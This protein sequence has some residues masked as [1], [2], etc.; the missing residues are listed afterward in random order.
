MACFLQ[1]CPL[2]APGA[3]DFLIPE[4]SLHQFLGSTACVSAPSLWLIAFGMKLA[5]SKRVQLEKILE[6]PMATLTIKDLQTHRDLDT[7]A[8]S[9]IRGANGSG[10]WV[11]GWIRPFIEEVTPRF[12]GAV[13]FF[14]TNNIFVADQM[15]NQVQA[16]DVSNSAANATITVNPK[17]LAGNVKLA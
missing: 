7:K 15:N 3:R 13:N 10:Q 6:I 5:R 11:F 16:I 1:I 2:V 9:R 8:M 14:Q 12:A 17:Q 4:W